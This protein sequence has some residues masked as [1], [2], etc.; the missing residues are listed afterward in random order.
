MAR[1]PASSS[2]LGCSPCAQSAPWRRGSRPGC[3]CTA[4]RLF[5]RRNALEL[6]VLMDGKVGI[7][8]AGLLR[9]LDD[10]IHGAADH[11]ELTV[12]RA[13]GIGHRTDAG[14]VGG[15]GG[16][17]PTRFGASAISLSSTCAT[18]ASEADR[19][20]RMALVKSQIS[21]VTPSSPS[22]LRR[23]VS[24]AGLVSGASSSFQSPV[25]STVPRS[26]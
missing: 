17:G 11:D 12:R 8:I 6:V 20:S 1:S 14:D 3:R 26:V 23:A 2:T 10:A 13:R 4:R 16:D 9:R 21:A 18:S 5:A 15:K 22:A 25:W 24:V 7:E 19:P